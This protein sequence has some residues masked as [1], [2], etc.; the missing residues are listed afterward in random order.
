MIASRELRFVRQSTATAT[1]FDGVFAS[2]LISV[3]PVGANRTI[4]P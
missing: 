4:H 2:H 1:I 3:A